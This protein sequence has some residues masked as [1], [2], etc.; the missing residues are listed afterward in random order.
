MATT[1]A[2]PPITTRSS[3]PILDHSPSNVSSPLSDVEDKD[4]DADEMDFDL[5]SPRTTNLARQRQLDD[6]EVA[7][8]SLSTGTDGD[9]SRLSDVDV[10]DSEAETERLYDTPPKNTAGRDTV[11][12]PGATE[13]GAQ[14]FLERRRPAFEP[15]PSKLQRQLN[16]QTDGVDDGSDNDSLSE[17]DDDASMA[18][19]EPDQEPK[20]DESRSPSPVKKTSQPTTKEDMPTSAT[21]DEEHN[22]TRKRKR[23][24]AA[25]QS[26]EPLRKRTGSVAAQGP[27]FSAD[28]TAII[29]DD[30]A[31]PVL[32]REPS[33]LTRE[34]TPEE[35]D[36]GDANSKSK[37]V[38]TQSIEDTPQAARSKSTKRGAAKKR[39]GRGGGGDG[40]TD[41]PLDSP[42]DAGTPAGDGGA[43]E[44]AHEPTADEEAE[45]AHKEEELERK[46]AAWEELAAIEKQF[47][48]FRERLYQERL[49]QLNREEAM[50]MDPNPTHPEYLAML[51]CIDARR[52]ERVRLSQIE[53]QLRMDLLKRKAVA[54]RAQIMTQ[55]HQGIRASRERV[56]EDLGREWYEIQHERR[57][58]ANNI[59]DFG[60]RFPASKKETVR[61]AVAYNK[62]VSIL[63]GVA[64]YAGFPAAPD[65]RGANAD[66]VEGDFEAISRTARSLQ[67]PPPP[68]HQ[69]PHPHQPPFRDE[70]VSVQFGVVRGALGPAAEQFLEQTPWANPNHPAHHGGQNRPRDTV[71]VAPAL[72]AGPA[73]MGGGG[74]G[75]RHSGQHA[76]GGGGGQPGV[77]MN[78]GG[79]GMRKSNSSAGAG[80]RKMEAVKREGLGHVV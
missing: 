71:G 43:E 8:P 24:S 13:T 23:S 64:K 12:R 65:I 10:N 75:R 5:L 53:L 19:N 80:G 20:A 57:R 61:Q 54:E 51:A 69:H 73:G 58:A 27:D 46:K 16:A 72:Y 15:S 29:D 32:T 21:V 62:E 79:T 44:E 56:L 7:S 40:G 49:D 47:S 74:G 28:D 9:E 68:Q 78:G 39:K 77:W 42:V 50:L 2:A 45:L 18:S 33:P 66:E 6:L 60:I 4:A 11:Y 14:L 76:G 17:A 37:D 48:N 36:G 34:P 70:P 26:G 30:I 35:E 1:E 55:Y 41:S 38:P 63:S 67:Q 22:D 52:D 31:T 25:D 3:P 59:P